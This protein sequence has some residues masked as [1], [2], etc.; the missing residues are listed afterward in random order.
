MKS[1]EIVGLDYSKEMIAIATLQKETE[2][3]SNLSWYKVMLESYLM[4]DGE[5][6]LCAVYE[7]LSGFSQTK[8]KAFAEIFR[9]LKPGSCFCGC[10]YVK[11]ERR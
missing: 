3:I 10:F 7:R 6:R 5:L 2:N 11:G 4:Q 1:V 8:E 9:V